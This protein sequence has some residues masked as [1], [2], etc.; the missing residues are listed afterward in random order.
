MNRRGQ[1]TGVQE[2]TEIGE[3]AATGQT[4]A[5]TAAVLGCSIWTVRKWRRR[6]TAADTPDGPA[7]P[8]R[9]PTGPLGT[10]GQTMR[11]AIIHLR[12]EHPGWG[13]ATILA[14]LRADPT[15]AG[16]HLPSRSRVAAFL[17]DTGLTRRYQ[18]H[19]EL[20][21]ARSTDAAGPHATWQL[22]A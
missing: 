21:H 3:W 13:A 2:R 11:E 10:T 18:R 4:D 12:R 19:S 16:E 7:R 20:P 14:A 22:D 1:W 9:P 17:R 6:M 5:Q 8:G 15:W